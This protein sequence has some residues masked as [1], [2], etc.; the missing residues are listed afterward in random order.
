MTI[1]EKEETKKYSAETN[2][3]YKGMLVC[4][5]YLMKTVNRLDEEDVVAERQKKEDKLKQAHNNM[6]P[7]G[8]EMIECAFQEEMEKMKD[9]YKEANNIDRQKCEICINELNRLGI[10]LGIKN[11]ERNILIKN[12][13]KNSDKIQKS[14]SIEDFSEVS[15][16]I[17]NIYCCCNNCCL[18]A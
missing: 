8:K 10:V 13:D 6:G 12:S 17:E 7:T 5:E 18:I 11:I 15:N 14:N 4:F 2:K 16:E 3:G 9:F 1:E